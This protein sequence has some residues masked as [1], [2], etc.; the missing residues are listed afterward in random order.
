VGTVA[1]VLIAA[2]I[3]FRIGIRLQ[4]RDPDSGKTP[5]TGAVVSGMLGLMAFLMAFT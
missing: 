4:R 2:E 5:V 1:L 3:G